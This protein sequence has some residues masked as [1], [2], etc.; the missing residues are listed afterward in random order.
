MYHRKKLVYIYQTYHKSKKWHSKEL[1]S[2]YGSQCR[3]D[4]LYSLGLH[5]RSQESTVKF[6]TCFLYFL[7][8]SRGLPHIVI[9]CTAHVW[10]CARWLL[11]M[12]FAWQSS[13]LILSPIQQNGGN[14]YNIL[15]F[16]FS[17]S[18]D[19]ATHDLFTLLSRFHTLKTGIWNMTHHQ[20]INFL[21][22]KLC[23]CFKYISV[24]YS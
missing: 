23:K 2:L 18:N 6:F 14:Q 24:Y 3:E 1:H 16:N 19:D 5:V 21:Q 10:L 12:N 11:Q 4:W 15:P 13:Q 8:V 22:R 7:L 20:Q 9:K 17:S